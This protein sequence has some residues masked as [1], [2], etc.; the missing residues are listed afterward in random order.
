M[1]E[2]A[3][4]AALLLLPAI[5]GCGD[6]ERSELGSAAD[7]ALTRTDQAMPDVTTETADA[8]GAPREFRF[9][10]RQEFAQS[11]RQD[12]AET[13]RRIEELSAQARSAGGAVSDR[14]L[15]NVRAARRVVQRNLNRVDAASAE[16]WE[17]VRRGVGE[18]VEHLDE[19]V[20][21]AY[22]K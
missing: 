11:I 14:A 1:R 21:R 17:E 22:P 8:P 6:R 12:L 5:Q 20:E 3:F 13:D 4:V 2:V 19:A 9:E 15:A 18:A 7:T 16:N 10:E